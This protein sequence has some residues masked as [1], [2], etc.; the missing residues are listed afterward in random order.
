MSAPQI[1]T[2]KPYI[3]QRAIHTVTPKIRLHPKMMP[4]KQNPAAQERRNALHLL[5]PVRA[6]KRGTRAIQAQRES[7]LSGKETPRRSPERRARDMRV[8]G[9]FM[10]SGPA[11]Q[12][13][14]MKGGG[15]HPPQGRL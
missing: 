6:I 2:E 1:P 14:I 10:V 5:L 13:F 7:L 4:K 9:C 8:S 15:S 3:R 12:F 11:W